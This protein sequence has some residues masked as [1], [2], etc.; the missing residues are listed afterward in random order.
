MKK[1]GTVLYNNASLYLLLFPNKNYVLKKKKKY[2]KIT[3]VCKNVKKKRDCF[4][5]WVLSIFV[6]I[7]PT[8]AS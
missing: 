6:D 1:K 3:Y 5:L 7:K 8:L 2:I 4:V